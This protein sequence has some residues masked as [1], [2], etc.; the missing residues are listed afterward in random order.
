MI[1]SAQIKIIHTLKNKL[2]LD[3]DLYR[4]MLASFDV[5][6]S[7]DLTETEAKIFIQILND[8]V[9]IL[10]SRIIR[11]YD[12][13]AG[14][15]DSMATPQQMRKIEAVWSDICKFKDRSQQAR[16][17]RRFTRRQYKVDDIRFLSKKQASKYIVALEKIKI[18]KD[19]KAI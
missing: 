19:L 7:K 4:D 11:K 2:C 14:R 17:L 3:D 5:C 10:K 18:E 6:S 1:T 8:K 9:K 13:F 12:D 16:T 15:D